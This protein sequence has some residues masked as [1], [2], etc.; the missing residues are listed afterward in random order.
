MDDQTFYGATLH[1]EYCPNFETVDE[2]REK[3]LE[4][5]RVVEERSENKKRQL[6][7]VE[8]EEEKESVKL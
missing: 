5:I 8:E 3:L 2:T 7:E 4:R 6:K 1:I